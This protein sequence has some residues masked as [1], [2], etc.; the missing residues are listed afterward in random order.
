[1]FLNNENKE[2]R[3]SDVTGAQEAREML[4]RKVKL[5]GD[6]IILSQSN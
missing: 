5:V 6:V 2:R 1:M 3:E 4:S